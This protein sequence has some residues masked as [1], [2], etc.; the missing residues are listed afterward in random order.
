MFSQEEL[1]GNAI[2]IFDDMR[3]YVIK[4]VIVLSDK[5]TEVG[6]LHLN[7]SMKSRHA[8]QVEVVNTEPAVMMPPVGAN[9]DDIE[10][11]VEHSIDF[12]DHEISR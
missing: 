12:R 4:K 8:G 1:I 10:D 11:E 5:G 7:M 2:F 3:T 6:S 9:E